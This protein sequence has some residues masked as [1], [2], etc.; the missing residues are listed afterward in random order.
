MHPQ[1]PIRTKCKTPHARTHTQH[2]LA[3]NAL[4][5]AR[6]TAR[7]HTLNA[8][9]IPH[10]LISQARGPLRELVSALLAVRP[11]LRPSAAD[12][13]RH[14]YLVRTLTPSL[15]PVCLTA[16]PGT[17]CNNGIVV[18]SFQVLSLLLRNSTLSFFSYR[19]GVFVFCVFFLL[20]F[21]PKT[22]SASTI[23]PFFSTSF[24]TSWVTMTSTG[25]V[26]LTTTV[27]TTTTGV[28]VAAGVG[29]GVEVQA[30]IKA[31]MLKAK[32]ISKNFLLLILVI[33]PIG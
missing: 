12:C 13:R 19:S 1:T 5:H 2:T 11:A 31:K 23:L 17:K 9:S 25:T 3:H 26:S 32:P 28:A 8:S 10:D 6:H 18:F 21:F 27:S 14:P 7:K 15:C 16:N 24:S 30:A 33:S 20:F 4:T 22:P 29:G